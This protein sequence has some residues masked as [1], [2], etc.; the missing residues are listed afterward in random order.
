MDS[1]S[2]SSPE[3]MDSTYRIHPSG[4]GA[5][6]LLRFLEM[7]VFREVLQ[8]RGV[9]GNCGAVIEGSGWSRFA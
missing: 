7:L 3:L 5:S 9:A 2:H 6:Y 1:K 4:H 8:S